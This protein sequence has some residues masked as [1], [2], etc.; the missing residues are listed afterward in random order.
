MNIL[1]IG[2]IVGRPGRTALKNAIGIL[3]E[4]YSAEIVI[5]NGENASGGL[6]I[7]PKIVDEL[8]A[9][10]VDIFTSGN[11]IWKRRDIFPLLDGPKIIRPANY[12]PSAPGKGWTIIKSGQYRIGVINLI[13]RTFMEALDSPFTVADRVIEEIGSSADFLIVDIQA[14]ATSEKIAL[15]YYLDGCIRDRLG[16]HTHVQTSDAKILQ[17]GTAYI[18]DA[19]MTGSSKGVIGVEKEEII[20][21]FITGLP[22]TFKVA[23]GG[24]EVQGVAITLAEGGRAKSIS[25]FRFPVEIERR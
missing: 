21:R 7:T 24:E 19:G 3:K 10:G 16:T 1:F 23:K 15:G 17:G 25:S 4:K 2:D 6:G 9:A 18:T 12:P 22:F 20:K 5:A 14:E 11:H 13:G 8:S